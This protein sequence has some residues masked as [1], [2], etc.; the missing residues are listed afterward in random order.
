M[1]CWASVKSLVE[2]DV[3]IMAAHPIMQGESRSR[4]SSLCDLFGGAL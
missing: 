4:N 3:F 2:R 1:S